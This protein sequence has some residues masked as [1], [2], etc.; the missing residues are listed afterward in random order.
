VGKPTYLELQPT[1]VGVFNPAELYLDS[2]PGEPTY[3]ITTDKSINGYKRGCHS[4]N[5]VISLIYN[6]YFGP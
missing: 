6:W 1:K 5:G 2:A 3:P 4:I